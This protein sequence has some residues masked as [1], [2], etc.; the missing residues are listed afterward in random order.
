M[1][2]WI[3]IFL[4]P[5]L[6]IAHAV[7]VDEMA[8]VPFDDERVRAY[9]KDYP[10]FR[11]FVGK[12]TD[13]FGARIAP[14]VLL[15]RNTAPR[16]YRTME[17]VSSFRDLLA[18]S[19][20]PLQRARGTIHG[21]SF[22]IQYSDYFDFYPWMYNEQNRHLVC[23][24]PAL[25]AL[26]EVRAF[27]GQSSPILSALEFNHMAIDV[28]MLKALLARW[29]VRYGTTKP[30][31]AD[32]ALFRSLNM[33]VAASKMPAGADV[34]NFALGRNIGLWVSAFEILT[35]TGA[36]KVRLWDVYDKIGAAPLEGQKD[37]TQ[38]LQPS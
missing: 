24:T 14:G 26:H 16:T 35:H 28:P 10:D 21:N 13:P 29:R 20:I 37:D 38:V 11:Q 15:L 2:D 4:L 22:H 19:V 6:R 3:P 27:K 18:L 36:D 8:I 34:T 1:S 25:L 9:E 33:A 17:A 30:V 12:F 31:W 7:A 23:S 5:N 32:Q